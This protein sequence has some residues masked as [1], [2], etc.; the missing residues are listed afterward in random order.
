MSD[1]TTALLCRL[2]QNINAV[3]ASVD[4]LANWVEQRGSVDT[5]DAVREHLQTLLKNS[6]EISDLIV[7][8]LAH[9]D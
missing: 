6:D 9:P 4:I 5:S 8:L 1:T 7:E 3:G 2:N